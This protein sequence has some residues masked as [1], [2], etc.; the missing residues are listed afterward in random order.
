MGV[1]A[2]AL[3]LPTEGV[4]TS[5]PLDVELFRATHTS[6]LAALY[7]DLGATPR[8]MALSAPQVTPPTTHPIIYTSPYSHIQPFLGNLVPISS[9]KNPINFTPLIPLPHSH[10]PPQLLIHFHNCLF[11]PPGVGFLSHPCTPRHTIAYHGISEIH[12]GAQK[13]PIGIP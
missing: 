5:K 8:A 12:R 9:L 13:E 6:L 4:F 7:M 2:E 10:S 1:G 3:I 11:I